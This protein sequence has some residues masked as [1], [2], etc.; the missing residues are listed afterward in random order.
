MNTVKKALMERWT[1]QAPAVLS[2]ANIQDKYIRENMAKL[3]ENQKFQDV[4]NALNEDFGMGVGAPL[5]ADQGIP[6]GG[7]SKAVFA[8]ISLALV[9]RVFPQ[10]F[11]NVLVGVQP[12][13]GPVGL[14]FALRYIY[15]DAGDPNKLVEAA[16][17]AV[18]EYS[19]FSGSTANTSGEPDAGTGVDTQSAE[20]WK[21]TGDYDEIQTHNDFS[22]G[23][24]G[25]IPELGLMFSRQS[26]VAKTRKLAASFSLESAEDIKR[27]QGVEMM[28]EMV[29][30]LQYEMTAEIDRETIA[31]CKSLC[32]PVFCKAGDTTDVSNGFVGRWSQERYSRIVGLIM[33]T[34][35]DIATATR[36]SAANIA[37]VSPD[38]ASV[39]Q[40]AA[41]FFNKVTHDVNGSTATPEIG[42]IN[43]AIKVFRDNYAVNYAGQDNGE[44]LLAYK[45]TGVSDCGVVF[46]PYVTG[47]VNQAI[48]PNDFS[49]RVGVMSRYAFAN[50]MLGA[51]NYY[52]LL[53][54]ETAKIWADASDDN[55]TF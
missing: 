48:D 53:K 15:K 42:T 37:V 33:K 29:N 43:G 5:G 3:M 18:P 51:D 12:L 46:C 38:M 17:K 24:R 32:K 14:A 2:V 6:H 7:D 25:K 36:R 31:R 13:S 34:A 22:T 35:N 10:L 49:P 39:L 50:N 20:A 47:V 40:Q 8:P 44:V 23:L 54:F 9:R 21:I 11:A 1:T 55:Y 28:T 16:W 45:G 19:G 52:R 27:M 4:G 30:V 26:I 41:P